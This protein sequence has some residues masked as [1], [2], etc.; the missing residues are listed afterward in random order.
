MSKL[1]YLLDS[2]ILS[3]PTKP[4]PHRH[5]VDLLDEHAHHVAMSVITWHELLYGCKRLPNGKKK[6]RLLRYFEELIAPNVP[7]LPFTRDMALW[8]ADERSRLA[9]VG[10]SK[11]FVDGQIA[12]TAAVEGMTLVTRNTKDFVDY[13][14][15]QFENWF[16]SS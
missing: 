3:E 6:T 4:Q 11:P 12:A 5:V 10:R 14:G 2:N 7:I 13:E 9:G 1:I 15:L 8:L 16:E